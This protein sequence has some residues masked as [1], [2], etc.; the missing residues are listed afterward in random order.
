MDK[1]CVFNRLLSYVITT[2]QENLNDLLEIAANK[3]KISSAV[4]EVIEKN[5]Y[6]FRIFDEDIKRIEE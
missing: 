3:G 4:Y 2:H 5:Y 6:M 1:N